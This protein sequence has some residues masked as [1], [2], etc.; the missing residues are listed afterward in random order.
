MAGNSELQ[1]Y[2]ALWKILGC[3]GKNIFYWLV[4]FIP[5]TVISFMMAYC[6]KTKAIVNNPVSKVIKPILFLPQVCA[7]TACALVL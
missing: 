1:E 4:K 6:L 3:F 2:S 7:T 5:V